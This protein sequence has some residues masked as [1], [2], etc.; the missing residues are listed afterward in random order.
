MILSVGDPSL[1]QRDE[2][3][4]VPCLHLPPR[5]AQFT[6]YPLVTSCP[7]ELPP[8]SPPKLRGLCPI[9][10]EPLVKPGIGG[11]TWLCG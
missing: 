11:K 9:V 5:P 10:E 6:L 3:C 1:G 2:S 8:P 4:M 7:Q